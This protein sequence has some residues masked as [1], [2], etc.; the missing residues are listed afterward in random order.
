MIWIACRTKLP[1]NAPFRE[2]NA[3]EIDHSF[4]HQV[5][6]QILQ[7][8]HGIAHANGRNICANH[9]DRC[10]ETTARNQPTGWTAVTAGRCNMK[11]SSKRSL[12]NSVDLDKVKLFGELYVVDKA[13]IKQYGVLNRHHLDSMIDIQQ[14]QTP[15][16]RFSD[17]VCPDTSREQSKGSSS[18]KHYRAPRTSTVSCDGLV[19]Q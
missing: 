11:C 14:T 8:C 15:I 16:L 4:A 18:L 9:A 5:R 10:C 19:F 2:S 7:V 12:S 6:C 3:V 1:S 13:C 17:S